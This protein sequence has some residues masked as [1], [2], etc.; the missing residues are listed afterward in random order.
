MTP[1]I[2][3]PNYVDMKTPKFETQS[4][5]VTIPDLAGEAVAEVVT[6]PVEMEWD[7]EI[8]EW[9]ITPEVLRKIEDTKP[10]T[11]DFCSPRS[12]KNCGNV[13]AI[14][15][16][17]WAN[18]SKLAKKAG[19]VGSPE[20]TAPAGATT[21]QSEPFMMVKSPSIIFLSGLENP[22]DQNLKYLSEGKG[23]PKLPVPV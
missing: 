13:T 2:N 10:A 11:W 12:S 15:K 21:S 14:P 3:C 17:K 6:I 16:K 9:L 7:E 5:Q 8:Q 4:F 18:C 22:C 1:G 20:N 19:P 23:R